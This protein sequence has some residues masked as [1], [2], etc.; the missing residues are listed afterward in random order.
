[1]ASCW[2]ANETKVLSLY[3]E[4]F[5][6]PAEFSCPFPQYEQVIEIRKESTC[7][8][9]AQASKP[10]SVIHRDYQTDLHLIIKTVIPLLH[11]QTDLSWLCHLCFST[12]PPVSRA[13]V[14][15]MGFFNPMYLDSHSHSSKHALEVSDS[16]LLQAP[17]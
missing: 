5:V 15:L 7:I 3:C 8:C 4:V 9:F 2:F 14:R 11:S 13:G 16:A 12:I 6:L 10:A 1:M 17:L